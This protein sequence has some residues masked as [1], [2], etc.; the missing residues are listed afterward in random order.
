[1]IKSVNMTSDHMSLEC[2]TIFICFALK[3]VYCLTKLCR[4]SGRDE[5][6][7]IHLSSIY[8]AAYMLNWFN[9]FLVAIDLIFYKPSWIFVF[10]CPKRHYVYMVI[11]LDIWQITLEKQSGLKFKPYHMLVYRAEAVT[12]SFKFKQSTGTRICGSSELLQVS[13]NKLWYTCT[14]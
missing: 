13:Y 7:Q 12:M 1:M 2:E 4:Y 9:L 6:N 8:V 3:S 11:I 10:L 14:D 5:K